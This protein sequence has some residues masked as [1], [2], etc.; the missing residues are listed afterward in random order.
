L[1][2]S[3]VG[4]LNLTDDYE[5]MLTETLDTVTNHVRFQPVVNLTNILR[6]DFAPI[7]F[8]QKKLQSQ[9][10]IREKLSKR[11]LL[12]I[13]AARKMLVKLTP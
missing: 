7:L 11:T 3:D 1:L 12:C 6:T 2:P 13:R 8:H 9:I 10:V 4:K 5:V